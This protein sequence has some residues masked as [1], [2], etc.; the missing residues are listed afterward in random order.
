MTKKDAADKTV[1][2]MLVDDHYMVRMGMQAILECE[3]GFKVVASV[4]SGKEAIEVWERE[5]PDVTLL[6]MRIPDLDGVRVLRAIRQ[7]SLRAKV[8]AVSTFDGDEDVYQAARAGANGFLSKASDPEL[9]VKAIRRVLDGQDAFPPEIKKKL[10]ERSSVKFTTRH[11][12]MLRALQ[13]GLTNDEIAQELHISRD[14]VKTHLKNLYILLDVTGR[15]EAVRV[16][17]E[18]G[19]LKVG[20]S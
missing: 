13:R 1:R 11:Y 12:D 19:F 3:S 20:P 7:Y 2:L 8:I 14:T 17:V 18:R 6:D 5:R 10:E 15:V 16:A 9:L 4:G